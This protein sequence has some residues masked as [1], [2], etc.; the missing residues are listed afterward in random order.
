MHFPSIAFA[1]V[2]GLWQQ[3]LAPKNETITST[4]HIHVTR[5]VTN[6]GSAIYVV[7]VGTSAA[8]TEHL[9]ATMTTN[10]IPW[11]AL[12]TRRLEC[13]S[14][15]QSTSTMRIKITQTVNPIQATV[16]ASKVGTLVSTITDVPQSLIEE[17]AEDAA[18][19]SSS[20]LAAAISSAKSAALVHST[21]AVLA[22]TTTS[23]N[24][25][26]SPAVAKS[27]PQ[28]T[29]TSLSTLP[30][31]TTSDSSSVLPIGLE[32]RSNEGAATTSSPRA[33]TTTQVPGAV[34]AVIYGTST[35]IMTPIP[36]T[37]SAEIAATQPSTRTLQSS[38]SKEA[39]EVES[40][41]KSTTSGDT[42]QPTDANAAQFK[43][44]QTTLI[45]VA[46]YSDEAAAKSTA[47]VSSATQKGSSS[48]AP[49]S[50]STSASSSSGSVSSNKVYTV[51]VTTSS[52]I[53]SS[54]TAE[55]SIQIT[56]SSSETSPF[57]TAYNSQSSASSAADI[58]ADNAAGASGGDSGSFKLSKAGF[59]AIISVVSIGVGL[60]T[61]RMYSPLP[62]PL[63]HSTPSSMESTAIY[64]QGFEKNHWTLFFSP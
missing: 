48:S 54:S 34:I 16:F 24:V 28:H 21:V 61:D 22:T 56:A 43:S 23:S 59:A 2:A 27:Q 63:R 36:A 64:R 60:G 11:Q 40:S 5:T 32:L 17:A 62:D 41:T 38:S 12:Q 47:A 29:N 33:T 51:P 37:L 18:E 52:A 30:F 58:A 50:A 31:I 15:G 46:T 20:Q 53:F 7:L 45:Q 4:R 6:T 26:V 8:Y 42:L 57:F 10:S 55:P 1:A 35:S 14:E 13:R 3:P 44:T 49:V 25:E 39:T 9:Q 19:L